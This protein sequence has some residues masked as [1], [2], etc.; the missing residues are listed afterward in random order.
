MEPGAGLV[1]LTGPHTRR[2]RNHDMALDKRS[3]PC[4]FSASLVPAG[5]LVHLDEQSEI[6]DGRE[7]DA[8]VVLCCFPFLQPPALRYPLLSVRRYCHRPR[9]VPGRSSA[10]RSGRFWCRRLA[11][12]AASAPTLALPPDKRR[13]EEERLRDEQI[14]ETRQLGKCLNRLKETEERKQMTEIHHCLSQ[15]VMN[16]QAPLDGSFFCQRRLFYICQLLLNSHSG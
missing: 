9:S 6:S 14:H 3:E 7:A 8:V 11:S 1:P 5:D 13:K 12:C 4:T 16:W 10:S 15:S 2:C